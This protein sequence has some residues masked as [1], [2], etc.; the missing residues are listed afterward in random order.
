M[1]ARG[2]P[3]QTELLSSTTFAGNI[4]FVNTG[5]PTADDSGDSDGEFF[6]HDDGEAQGGDG[7]QVGGRT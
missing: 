5:G 6:G 4:S 1:V 7:G 2:L 3:A